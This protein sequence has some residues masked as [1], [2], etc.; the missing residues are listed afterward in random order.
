MCTKEKSSTWKVVL[1]VVGIMAVAAAV[2]AGVLYWKK[3]KDDE[4]RLEEEI[5]ALIEQKFA[6]V[7]AEEE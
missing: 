2:V 3:K 4:K 6:E 5:E 1:A 7:E